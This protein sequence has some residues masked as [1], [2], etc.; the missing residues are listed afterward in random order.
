MVQLGLGNP[1]ERP[2]VHAVMFMVLTS[3]ADT[4]MD[5]PWDLYSTFVLEEKHG[6]NKQ[7]LGFYFKDQIKKFAVSQ[8][9][10]MTWIFHV[11]TMSAILC[12]FC[13]GHAHLGT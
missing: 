5:M 7:T 10:A 9:A 13:Y 6:F 12:L 2:F 4:I 11:C 1:V 8:V 3:T